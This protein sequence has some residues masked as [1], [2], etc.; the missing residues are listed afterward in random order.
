MIMKRLM[1][2]IIAVL[3][4]GCGSGDD[5]APSGATAKCSDGSYSY[6]QNCSGTCS[7][8]GGVSQWYISGCGTPK[9]TVLN[10]YSTNN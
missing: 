4:S 6:S 1:I 3:I 5:N 8:H 7:S 10:L 2:L 9:E